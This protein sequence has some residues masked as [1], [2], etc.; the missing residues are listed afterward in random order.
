MADFSAKNTLGQ[1]VL[2]IS[3]IASAGFEF[4]VPVI[5]AL[6]LFSS[7]SWCWEPRYG[8]DN[9]L[10]LFVDYGRRVSLF[11]ELLLTRLADLGRFFSEQK[12]FCW[13][14]SSNIASRMFRSL[15]TRW[16]QLHAT[17][18]R[19]VLFKLKFT[20]HILTLL[21][22]VTYTVDECFTVYTNKLCKAITVIYGNSTGIMNLRRKVLLK[23]SFAQNPK[24]VTTF[25]GT[26]TKPTNWTTNINLFR[27]RVRRNF[28]H[29][30][31]RTTAQ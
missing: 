4:N 16:R 30:L 26:N 28:I 11:H 6:R 5:I 22:K 3:A 31:N 23:T 29:N 8:V 15:F 20:L 1:C 13:S 10:V 17:L 14:R 12:L 19:T 27:S 9:S 24:H 25:I 18:H 21:L 7:S 2:M